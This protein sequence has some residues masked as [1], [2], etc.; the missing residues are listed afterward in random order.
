MGHRSVLYYV[1]QGLSEKYHQTMKMVLIYMLQNIPFLPNEWLLMAIQS[2]KFSSRRLC[3]V[4]QDQWP[5]RWEFNKTLQRY[6]LRLFFFHCISPQ[7][8]DELF[9]LQLKISLH[10]RNDMLPIAE[11]LCVMVGIIKFQ[12]CENG[13]LNSHVKSFDRMWYI[14]W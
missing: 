12:S 6:S 8:A 4:Q 7:T 13:F 10:L 5:V 9:N 1:P 11:K 2:V 3:H 14:S